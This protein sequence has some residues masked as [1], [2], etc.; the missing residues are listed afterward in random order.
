MSDR[1]AKGKIDR[2]ILASCTS[3]SSKYQLLLAEHIVAGRF[4][5]DVIAFNNWTGL[6]ISRHYR[7]D[8]SDEINKSEALRIYDEYREKLQ[9]PASPQEGEDENPL[10][11]FDPGQA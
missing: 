1:L 3:T 4:C 10:I 5:Y 2:I 8:L 6:S 7:E 9:A 11:F